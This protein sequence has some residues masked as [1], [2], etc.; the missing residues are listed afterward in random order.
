[1]KT[2]K[3]TISYCQVPPSSNFKEQVHS[4][5]GKQLPVDTH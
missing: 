2:E 4:V 1:M 5:V 3:A